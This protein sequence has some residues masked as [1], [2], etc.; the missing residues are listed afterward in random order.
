MG[1]ALIDSVFGPPLRR[2]SLPGQ[3]I[4]PFTQAYPQMI[5]E[6]LGVAGAGKSSLRRALAR[7]N[8]RIQTVPPP[9]KARYLPAL[10]QVGLFWWPIYCTRYPRSRWFTAE[11]IRLIGYLET[12]IPYI[13]SQIRAK[14]LV[15]VLDPGSIYWLAALQEFAPPVAHDRYFQRWWERKLRLWSC[16]LDIVVWLEAPPEI[17][18][19]RVMAR[20]EWHEAKTQE[21]DSALDTFRRFQVAY[22]RL[23]SQVTSHKAVKVFHYQTDQVSTEQ[24][25]EELLSEMGLGG[26]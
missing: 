4:D 7:R 25:A 19:R 15:A 9:N 14:G 11:E 16:V 21:P 1:P 12:W 6:M 22:Q 18:L 20:D 23:I 2:L 5:I 24:M 8:P 26:R 3:P 13:R 17:L 10:A